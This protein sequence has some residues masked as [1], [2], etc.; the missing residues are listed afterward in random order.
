MEEILEL[1]QNLLSGNINQALCIVE[2][3]EE[4]GRKSIIENLESFLVILLIHLIKNQVEQR[5]TSSW[6]KSILNSLVAIQKKNKLGKKAYY[7]YKDEW[8][9]YI[10]SNYPSALLNS[11]YEIR[12]G[13]DYQE[14]KMLVAQKDLFY[15][16]NSLLNLTYLK[17]QDELIISVSNELEK[18]G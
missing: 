8:L 5:L 1:K 15:L 16:T 11:S 7:I 6:K 10:E 3:L 18:L 13:M 17:N 12:G 14:L 9:E 2:E 4:V